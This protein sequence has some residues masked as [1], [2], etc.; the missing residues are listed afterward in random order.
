MKFEES[1]LNGKTS[2]KRNMIPSW[3]TR[4]SNPSTES[5]TRSF[6][7]LTISRW[8][9]GKLVATVKPPF[10]RKGRL[11][12]CGNQAT[13]YED[14]EVAAGGLCAV[15]TRS[16]VSKASHCG[17]GCATVD[18]KTA[19]FLQAPSWLWSPCQQLPRKFKHVAKNGGCCIDCMVEVLE[20][21]QS[22]EMVNSAGCLQ[23][24]SHTFGRLKS[25]KRTPRARH[26]SSSATWGSMWMIFFSWPQ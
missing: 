12:A 8:F 25:W 14:A 22:I 26:G 3:S 24:W 5:S 18:V 17:W 13:N 20:T 11:V 6:K 7:E 10:K 23:H 19:A 9:L 16:L 2:S 21:G 1:W 4:P 15:S